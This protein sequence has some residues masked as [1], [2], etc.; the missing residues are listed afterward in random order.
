MPNIGDIF[1]IIFFI[2]SEMGQPHHAKHFLARYGNY[3]A[4]Y[5]IETGR[6]LNGNMPSR[7]ERII[8]E[9][10]RQHKDDFLKCWDMLNQENS[11]TPPKIQFAI[12]RKNGRS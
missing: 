5:D 4:N 6:R 7:Q 8:N 12:G 9:I 2:Y 3:Q 10:L 11:V 1:G